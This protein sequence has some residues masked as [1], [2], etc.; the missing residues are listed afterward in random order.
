MHVTKQTAHKLAAAGYPQPNTVGGCSAWYLPESS[1]GNFIS[2]ATAPT[3]LPRFSS[4]PGA[5][6]APNVV[7]L[8]EAMS[9]RCLLSHTSGK[10]EAHLRANDLLYGMNFY[11]ENPAEALAE[12]YL[13]IHQ[14]PQ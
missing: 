5:I 14:P 4:F 13:H 6:Y 2:A 8:L 3:I 9:G 10:W 12:A 7:E 1:G 11:H